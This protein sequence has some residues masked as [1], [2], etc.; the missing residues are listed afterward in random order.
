MAYFAPYLDE[1]GLHL[2]TYEERLENLCEAYRA[3][4]GQEAEL[5]P[6]VPDYQLLSVL[7]KASRPALLIVAKIS[8]LLAPSTAAS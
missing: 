2:P 5:S 8:A 4:F 3:I 6:A 1:A 7:A